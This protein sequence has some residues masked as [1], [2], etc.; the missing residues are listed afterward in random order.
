[1]RIFVIQPNLAA[2]SEVWL[3]RMNQMLKNHICG[4]AAFVQKGESLNYQYPVF[5]LNGRQAKF[6]ERQRIRL[7]T[8]GTD[9]H[10]KI[11]HELLATIKSSKADIILVHYATTA[12]YLWDLLSTLKIPIYIHV[13]G[14]D[15]IWDHKDENGKFIHSNTYASE[16]NNISQEENVNFIANSTC[17]YNNLISIGVSKNKIAKKYYGVELPLHKRDYNK[18]TLDVLFLG[19]F[20]DFKGPDIVLEA[21]LQACEFGFQGTLVMAGDGPLKIMCE[22]IARRSKY[23][24]RIFFKGAVTKEQAIALYKSSDIYTMH[25]SIGIISNGY[26][27]FGATF[28]EAMSFGL[29]II[30]AA[31][32]GPSE[33]IENGEDGIFVQENNVKEHAE[34]FLAL[35]KDKTLRRKLGENSRH[36]VENKFSS[37]LEKTEFF[38]ILGIQQ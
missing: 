38:N 7:K 1:M 2:K 32:G 13:H 37:E 19:R 3:Y 4:V 14:Y 22:I 28:I 35:L 12:H 18:D 21:F 6:W 9:F 31:V 11:R 26:D 33:I 23:A 30:T 10:Q 34:A 36:K 8:N 25:N 27:T 29:P 15:I 20:V 5:N 17:S 16:I 24:D